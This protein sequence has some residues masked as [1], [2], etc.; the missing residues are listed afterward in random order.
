MIDVPSQSSSKP[1][2]VMFVDNQEYF[3]DCTCPFSE[4]NLVCKHMVAASLFLQKKYRI[5]DTKKYVEPAPIPVI[6]NFRSA[7]S[8]L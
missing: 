7:Q 8:S 3:G 5:S 1:Y 6:S 4:D 2:A